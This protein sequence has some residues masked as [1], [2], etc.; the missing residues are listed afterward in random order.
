MHDGVLVITRAQRPMWVGE[1]LPREYEAVN[2]AFKALRDD[3]KVARTEGGRPVAPA[4]FAAAQEAYQALRGPPLLAMHFTWPFVAQQLVPPE[5]RD[6]SGSKEF[7]YPRPGRGYSLRLDFTPVTPSGAPLV[8]SFLG[9]E[10]RG[11]ALEYGNQCV[12]IYRGGHDPDMYAVP[13][14]QF[15]DGRPLTKLWKDLSLYMGKDFPAMEPYLKV[16][17]QCWP[18]LDLGHDAAA[19]PGEP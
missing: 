7:R 18:G 8:V 4:L 12:S 11:R 17:F 10:M 1:R 2:A 6:T 19:A 14:A 15:A 5:V 3:A 9:W 13:P 16:C